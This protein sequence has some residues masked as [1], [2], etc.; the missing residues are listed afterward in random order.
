MYLEVSK[1]TTKLIL[2]HLLA[3]ARRGG[4]RERED[5]RVLR[6]VSWRRMTTA[7]TPPP[8]QNL[9]D[10]SIYHG[11]VG[12]VRYLPPKSNFGD[13]NRAENKRRDKDPPAGGGAW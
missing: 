13:K 10:N 3:A 6:P 8:A 12:F 4:G 5:P 1:D 7:R 9:R 11:S 2:S